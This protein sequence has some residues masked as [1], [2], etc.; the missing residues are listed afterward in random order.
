MYLP[1][2]DGINPLMKRG[3]LGAL[4]NGVDLKAHYI[5][6]YSSDCRDPKEQQVLHDINAG[7]AINAAASKPY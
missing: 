4:K 5:E 7:L 3:T 6:V 2:K 1:Y